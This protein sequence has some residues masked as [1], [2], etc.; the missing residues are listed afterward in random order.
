MEPLAIR[1]SEPGQGNPARRGQRGPDLGCDR[2]I[3]LQ[4]IDV[5]R[6]VLGRLQTHH[7]PGLRPL[8]IL[9]GGK[10]LTSP[11]VDRV[12]IL[13]EGLD[14]GIFPGHPER[15]DVPLKIGEELPVQSLSHPALEGP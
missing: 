3:K 13:L 6:P 8:R 11:L 2:R 9:I 14:P 7:P 4:E 1:R 10:G 5:I 15:L 12:P